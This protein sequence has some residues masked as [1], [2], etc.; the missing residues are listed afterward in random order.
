MFSRGVRSSIYSTDTNVVTDA[1][2][3]AIIDRL[4]AE[5][6]DQLLHS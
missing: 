1:I 3:L 6:K 4:L 5:F 2:G